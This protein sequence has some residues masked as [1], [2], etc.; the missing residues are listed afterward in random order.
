[1]RPT[2][3][4]DYPRRATTSAII[5]RHAEFSWAQNPTPIRHVS[6]CTR[7]SPLMT[8]CL[9]AHWRKPNANDLVS[10]ILE[11]IR[12]TRH[13]RLHRVSPHRD[14]WY[15][16][17]RCR[18]DVAGAAAEFL[19]ECPAETRC[20]FEAEICR[21][22]RDGTLVRRIGQ[23]RTDAK[24]SLM[25]DVARDATGS[26]EQT[27]EPGSG[28]PKGTARRDRVVATAGAPERSAARAPADHSR[29]LPAP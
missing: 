24:Q 15:A 1:M 25:L 10:G 5:R 4:D 12:E 20:I 23:Q 22:G 18:S 19:P 29:F 21:Y 9:P 11:Q 8:P 27:V 28:D 14:Q 13:L 26:F 16:S 2:H 17:L 7:Q 3:Y 6:K